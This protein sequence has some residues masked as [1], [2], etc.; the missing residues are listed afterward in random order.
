MAEIKGFITNLGKYNEGDL[1]GK[2]ITFPIDEDELNEVLKEIG[3]TYYN[4]HGERLNPF[5]EEFFFTDW[6]CGF[7]CGFGE[8]ESIE[9]INEIAEQLE[10]WE[11]DETLFN[12][13]VEIWGL[14]YVIETSPDE[15]NLYTDITTDYDLGYYWAVE[16]GCYNLDNMGHLVNYIN[17]ESFGRDIRFDTNGG[18]SE[19]GWI[20][21]VG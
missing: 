20:E 4:E 18:F 15:Y 11:D 5:Y 8:F 13:A 2:W 3:C 17:Y 14:N 19:Y 16:S 12:A 21:Y 6:E 1:I 10:C 9:R 7:D